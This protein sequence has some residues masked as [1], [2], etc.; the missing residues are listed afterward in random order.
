MTSTSNIAL[1]GHTLSEE[2]VRE[3]LHSTLAESFR[4]RR[5]LVLIPDFTRSL[6]LPFLFRML[7]ELLGDARKLDFLVALG[8]HPA[9]SEEQL[10]RLVGITVEERQAI[11]GRLGL[12]NHDWAN[13]SALESIGVICGDEVRT[14]AGDCW[15]PSLSGDV[16]VRVNRALL[17]C[18]QILIVSPVV[19]HEVA[20]FSGGAKYLFPGVSGPQMINVAHW[21]GALGGIPATIGVKDTP[22]RALIHSAAALL[23][24]PVTLLALVTEGKSLAGI[25]IGDLVSAWSAAADLSAQLHIRRCAHP[26]H[27]ALSCPGERYDE[28]WT[29][30][31]AMYKLEPV[32]SPEPKSSSTRR[33]S[34][35]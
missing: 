31:K 17:E 27:R 21:L 5:V 30:A 25:S 3:T 7:V 32:L 28:L 29:A 22:V 23:P 12:A 13:P 19:P 34:I 33:T 2:S 20:G 1:P 6:P 15:H 11:Y 26:F 10:C 4:G 16:D 14:I 9:L 35:P 8:T 18:D 24:V